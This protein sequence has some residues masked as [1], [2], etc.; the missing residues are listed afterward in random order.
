MMSDVEKIPCSVLVLTRNSAAT[1][2]R[3]LQNLSLFGEVLVHDGNSED[4]SVAIA[5]EYGAKVL[6][7]YPGDPVASV[8]VKD[9]TEIRLRQRADARCDW[10]LYLDAD[11]YM[12]DALVKEVGEILRTAAPKTIVKFRRYPVID[13][14]PRTRGM[15]APEIVPRIHHRLSGA[16]LK[17]GKLVHEKYVYDSSFQQIVAKSPLYVPLENVAALRVKDDRYLTL[18]VEKIRANGY[19]WSRYVRWVLLRE[20][21]V[22][23]SLLLRILANTPWYFRPEGVPFDHEWRYVCYHWR[24]FRAITGAMLAHPLAAGRVRSAATHTK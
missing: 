3:C 16:T 19:P 17:G 2:G 18:E 20:P 24:L 7:Q 15:Y 6:P 13:G 22:L 1:L 8:R 21:L 23:L 11:E 9:F 5:K 12:S 10:V 14:R 4:G